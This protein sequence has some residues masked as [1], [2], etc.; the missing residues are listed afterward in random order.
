MPY[1]RF[2]IVIMDREVMTDGFF[3]FDRTAVRCAL[4]LALAEQAEP[5]L[6]QIEPGTRGRGEVQM[7]TRMACKPSLHRR[8]LVRAV[9]IHD[10]M[11]IELRRHALIDGAQKLQ[12]FAAAMPPMQFSDDLARDKI[13]RREQ[14]RGAMA[15]IVMATPLSHP[16]RQRQQRLGAIECLNL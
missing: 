16:K 9:V 14:G 2:R 15:D 11:N 8:G 5:T 7:K 10:Q 3:E 6:N 13:Q 4:D 12:E 1:E